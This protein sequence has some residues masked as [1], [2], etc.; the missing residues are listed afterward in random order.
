MA[1]ATTGERLIRAPQQAS[2]GKLFEIT[3]ATDVIA[4]SGNR[5]VGSFA[6]AGRD[7]SC[8]KREKG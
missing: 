3:P 6:P 8:A 7:L 5:L 4:N 2:V 1:T